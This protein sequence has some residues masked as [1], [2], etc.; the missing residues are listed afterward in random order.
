[1]E[2]RLKEHLDRLEDTVADRT[3]ELQIAKERA[4]VASQA[5]TTFLANMSHELRT[6][7]NAI[8]GYAQ[9]LQMSGR[10]D[11]RQR[12]GLDT[13]RSS[14]QHLLALITDILDLAKVEAG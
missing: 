1:A 10:L 5:K 9:L 13:I 4:E 14:G 7:L 12:K 6:P 11:E 2:R 3:A 8:L